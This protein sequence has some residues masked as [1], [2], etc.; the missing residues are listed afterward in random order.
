MCSVPGLDVCMNSNN[1]KNTKYK[2]E[3]IR[4]VM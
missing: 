1:N 4:K 3:Y 2:M